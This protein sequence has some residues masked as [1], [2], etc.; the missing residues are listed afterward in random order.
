MS[1][2][3]LLLCISLL[4]GITVV[5]AKIRTCDKSSTELLTAG[6]KSARGKGSRLI[7]RDVICMT[8]ECI[9]TASTILG[10]MDP[11][12]DPC[13]NFYQFACGSFIKNTVIPDDQ[14]SVDTFSMI[15]DDLQMQLRTS[16]EE[17]IKP[18]ESRAFKLAKTLYQTC[19]DR[20]SIEE[21]GLQ[22]LMEVLE[23]LGGWP[24]LLENWDESNFDWQTSV[25][26]NRKIGYSVDHFLSFD[27]DVDPK[28]STQRMLTLDQAWLSLPREYLTKGLDDEIVK[29]YYDYMVD[30]AVILGAERNRA[31]TEMMETLHFEMALAN[32]S[33]PSERRRNASEL[34]NPMTLYELSARFPSIPWT[35]Y[36]DAL[37][38]PHASLQKNEIINLREPQFLANL[39]ALLKDSP[40]KVQANYAIW[41]VVRDSVDYL[42]EEI[43]RRQLAYWTEVTG[44]TEREP[45]WQ[46]CVGVVSSSLSLSVAALYVRKYFDEEAKKNVVDMVTD[47]RREFRKIMEK[48]DWMDERTRRAALEKV[49]AMSSFIAYPDELLDDSKLEQFYAALELSEGNYLESVLNVTLFATEY[50][51]SQLRLPVNKSDWITY[52]DSAVVNAYYSPNDNSM[53]FPA[54]I[55]QG[56][57]FSKDRPQYMNYGAIGFVMGHEITHGFDDQ[58]SQYDKNGDLVE[59]WAEETKQKFLQKAQCIIHQYGNYTDKEVGMNLNGINTQGENIA[60]NGG[61]KE[62]YL[63]YEDWVRRNGPEPLLPGLDY[64]PQQMFWISAA[65]V[66]CTKTRTEML[67]LDIVTDEHSPGEFR[68]VGPMSNMPEFAKDFKCPKGSNMNPEKRCSVW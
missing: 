33:L 2:C 11:D 20:S 16:I 49:D 17:E 23:A 24:V 45:R 8:P 50:S 3:S 44:E 1:A 67:K 25:Y 12:V 26:R 46:E 61:I 51:I 68:V 14:P 54:G 55:L 59:W 64:S 41:R 35:E 29:V 6:N 15:D 21:Q 47:I 39:E 63:A 57:F 5:A 9:H 27:I 4:I 42:D 7:G 22:P 52:G 30:V 37:L 36:L 48:V 18:N 28:N 56:E 38:S 32:I 58:G 10:N 65:N 13:D 66:W 53:Q 34:Y 60:D 19:M 62:A 40:K 31:E 43:R